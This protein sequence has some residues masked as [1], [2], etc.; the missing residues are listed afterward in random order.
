VKGVQVFRIIV[1]KE[2]EFHL[3]QHTFLLIIQLLTNMGQ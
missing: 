3:K 2:K 1:A